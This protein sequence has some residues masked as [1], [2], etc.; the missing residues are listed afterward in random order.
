MWKSHS[1]PMLRTQLSRND[2]ASPSPLDE[3]DAELS[4]AGRSVKRSC[5]SENNIHQALRQKRKAA[6][7]SRSVSQHSSRTMAGCR[8]EVAVFV[9]QFVYDPHR[10]ASS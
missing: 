2:A 3:T 5:L 10:S 9:L 4:G 6:V 1:K 8:R 7:S